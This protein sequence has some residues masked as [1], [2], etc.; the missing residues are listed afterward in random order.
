M[1]NTNLLVLMDEDR[2]NDTLRA[3]NREGESISECIINRLRNPLGE[4][5][6]KGVEDLKDTLVEADSDFKLT[7]EGIFEERGFVYKPKDKR[8]R[9][10]YDELPTSAFDISLGDVVCVTNW[11][12][13]NDMMTLCP[14][15]R[16]V[17]ALESIP[18]QDYE[19]LANQLT[20]FY[21]AKSAE[22]DGDICVER[23]NGQLQLPPSEGSKIRGPICLAVF[24]VSDQ[25]GSPSKPENPNIDPLVFLLVDHKYKEKG[26]YQ[27]SSKV[28][29]AVNSTLD[30]LKLSNPWLNKKYVLDTLGVKG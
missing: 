17:V 23:L 26:K 21:A 5:V 30:R 27:G 10:K 9:S 7:N 24:K 15:I 8:D 29:E 13:D 4:I 25:Y 11:L 1:K 3:R 16:K 19:D 18:T 12:N 14:R 22:S 2:V 28:R 6:P 20:N